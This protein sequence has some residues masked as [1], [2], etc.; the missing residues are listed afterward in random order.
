LVSFE[1]EV[2]F[3]DCRIVLSM[4]ENSNDEWNA[5]T[6]S[7]PDYVFEARLRAEE[8]LRHHFWQLYTNG[9]AFVR[10]N[11]EILLDSIRF[12]YGESV[13]SRIRVL[14]E[15][16]LTCG[17]TLRE[18]GLCLSLHAENPWVPHGRIDLLQS[19]NIDI[20]DV[21]ENR[22]YCPSVLMGFWDYQCPADENLELIHVHMETVHGILIR[23]DFSDLL[24][25]V[26]GN[27]ATLLE[28]VVAI[29]GHQYGAYANW[30]SAAREHS[31][32][33]QRTPV[34]WESLRAEQRENDD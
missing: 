33:V 8:D 30:R 15:R 5:S 4:A 20:Q 16:E 1:Q 3:V 26:R 28:T 22:D 2:S 25:S 9:P 18:M 10:S 27:H 11:V 32:S 19:L 13:S 6:A 21:L 7:F 23:C 14:I 29:L 12:L 24:E 31:S 34:D 17:T